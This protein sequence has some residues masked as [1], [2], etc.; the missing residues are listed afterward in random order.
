MGGKSAANVIRNIDRS[1]AN[2]LPRVITASASASSANAPRSFWP[3]PSAAWRRSR[4]A[5]HGG[6]ADGRGSRAQG[7][8]EPSCSSSASPATASWSAACARPACSS[9][10]TPP[11]PRRPAR[12]RARRFVITGTL[13]TLSR[14]EAKQLIETGRR[15]SLQRR[16]QEDQLPGGGRGRRAEAG[17]GAGTRHRHLTEEELLRAAH[18]RLSAD[19][20]ELPRRARRWAVPVDGMHHGS[21]PSA[22]RSPAPAGAPIRAC[23]GSSL[24][25][26]VDRQE[27]QRPSAPR[28]QHVPGTQNGGVQSGRADGLFHFSAR[29]NVL[30]HDRRRVRHADVNESGARRRPPPLRSGLRADARSMLR[31]CSSFAGLGC[32]TPTR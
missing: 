30:P 32:A 8:G 15:Q 27:H 24:H 4:T 19:L 13:P 21:R 16:E 23:A 17:Q 6:S 31:N 20:R 29:C 12:Y 2:P 14:E 11:V 18:D 3:K 26:P 1:R 22:P 25:H 28:T 5:S 9:P 7:R 10:T